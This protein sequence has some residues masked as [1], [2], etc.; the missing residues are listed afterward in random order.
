MR[1]YRY[2]ICLCLFVFFFNL[3]RQYS[4]PL[5]SC[6]QTTSSRTNESKIPDAIIQPKKSQYQDFACFHPLLQPND[7]LYLELWTFLDSGNHE[8]TDN[9][10]TCERTDGEVRS[11]WTRVQTCSEI[12]VSLSDSSKAFKNTNCT[13]TLPTQSRLR[14]HENGYP[15]HAIFF[16]K[17]G[18]IVVAEAPL[19]LTRMVK[20]NYI[21]NIEGSEKHSGKKRQQVLMVPHYKYFKQH[22]VLRLVQEY[23]LYTSNLTRGDG[24]RLQRHVGSCSDNNLSTIQYCYR[25][26]LYVDDTALLH[27]SHIELASPKTM[28]NVSSELRLNIKFSLVSPLQDVMIRHMSEGMKLVEYIFREEEL[29]EIR[30]FL[31]DENVHRFI[32]T[33]IISFIHLTLDFVAFRDEVKFYVGRKDLGGLS[34]SS[35]ITRFIS[36]LII[37]LYLYDQRR[38]SFIVLFSV[39]LGVVADGWKA[40]KVLKPSF[41]TSRFPFVHFRDPSNLSLVETNTA[42]YDR[43]AR[44]YLGLMF[45]PIMLGTALY[46]RRHYHYEN[47][48]S[49]I[50]SH[51]ANAVYAFGFIALCPQLYINYRLKSVAH[52]PW[53]VFV[54]KIFN[55]FIDDVFAFMIEMRKS[56]VITTLMRVPDE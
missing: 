50:I 5:K 9:S 44:T 7:Q 45:Y 40:V 34:I 23:R 18:D 43:I 22:V 38:T 42:K 16:L 35:V 55:T 36:S 21:T 31:S 48:W 10:Y 2:N 1:W 52:L 26:I 33:Q 46:A 24:L 54:Y 11:Q 56:H 6:V 25:P 29:D 28:R 8:C 27:A 20:K 3:E 14:G 51:A 39:F 19:E 4:R 53:K 37:F 47:H 13:I 17:R 30:W 32:L 12:P 49:W 15:L 41:S